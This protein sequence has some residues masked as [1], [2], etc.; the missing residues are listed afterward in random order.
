MESHHAQ[1]IKAQIEPG[2]EREDAWSNMASAWKA[3]PYRRCDPIL[4]ALSERIGANRTV[5]DVGGG[6]GRYALPLALQGN[7][8]IVVDSSPAMVSEIGPFIKKLTDHTKDMVLLVQS[9]RSP[10]AQVS[11][12]WE[13]VHQEKRIELPGSDYLRDVLLEM[14]IDLVMAEIEEAGPRPVKDYEE[15]LRMLRNL[16]FVSPGSVKDLRLWEGMESLVIE[17]DK[18]WVVKDAPPRR[19][20]LVSWSA[21]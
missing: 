8:V 13:M 11:P 3:D 16:T 7:Q 1:S 6:A 12:V 5:L 10:L 14:G 18:G 19:E 20:M 17:T 9:E 2:W 15:G 21:T 4:N